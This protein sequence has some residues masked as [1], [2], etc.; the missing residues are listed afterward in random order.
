MNSKLYQ[1]APSHVTI[2]PTFKI[3]CI[4][5]YYDGITALHL[6]CFHVKEEMVKFLLTKKADPLIPGGDN[7][8]FPLHMVCTKQTGAALAILLN[9][10]KVSGKDA[11]MHKDKNGAIPLLLAAECGNH[12][13]CRELATQQ[14]QEQTEYLHPVSGD[15]AIHV[16]TRKKDITTVKKEGQAPLHIASQNGDVAMA[17]VFFHAKANPNIQDN[18][19]RTPLHI[20]AQA[21]STSI[22]DFLTDKFKASVFERTKDGSTLIHIASE[23]GHPET[24]MVFLRKG[25]PLHMPNKAGARCIHIAA[26]RGHV[27]VV[28]A[29]LMKGENVDTKTNDNH[30]ALHIAVKHCKPLVV[31]LLLGYGAQVHI[32]AGETSET[33]LHIAARVQNGEK[34]AEMLLKSGT[35]VNS[36]QLNGETALH[37][38]AR[39]GHLKTTRLLLD[40]GALPTKRTN[41]GLTPLHMAINNCRYEVVRELLDLMESRNDR[42]ASEKLVNQ[43]T[44]DGKTSIHYAAAITKEQCSYENEDIEMIQLLLAYKGNVNLQ[45]TKT[46]ETPL[47][48]CAQG[49]N[50]SVLKEIVNHMDP[51]QLQISMN[52]QA[53]N[54]MSSLMMACEKGHLETVTLLLQHHARVD[55]FDE[56]GRM[57][58]HLAAEN[59]HWAVIDVLLAHKAFVNAK[60][61]SGVTPLHLAAMKGY[62]SLV[63]LLVEKFHA[64][65]DALTIKKRTPLHC[66]AETGQLE[67]CK[68][69]LDMKADTNAT[70]VY[71]QTPLHLGAENDHSDVVKLFLY[72]SPEL[73]TMANTKGFT[74]AHIAAMKGSVGVMKELMKFN[75]NIVTTAKT[76]VADSTTLHLAAEGGHADVVK[77]LLE[78]G[79]APDIENS[80]GLTAIHLAARYGHVGVLDALRTA[81]NTA[82]TSKKTGFTALHVAA[83]YGQTEFVRE[84][85]TEVPAT[86]KSEAPLTDPNSDAEL[87]PLHLA[88]KSGYESVVRLLLNSDGVQADARTTVTGMTPLHF[89]AQGGHV[90]VVGLLLSKSTSQLHIKD[91]FGRTGLH[92]ATEKGHY[93]MVA[94]L[95]GQG[96]EIN[97]AD[98]NG[99]T[100]LHYTAK[101]GFLNV[102]KLLCDSGALPSS[103]TKDA[104]IPLCLAAASNHY[105]VLNYLVH[106]D[107]STESLLEDKNRLVLGARAAANEKSY[108]PAWSGFNCLVSTTKVPVAVIRYLPFINANPSDYSTIYTTLLK[109]VSIAKALGQGRILVT[110]DLAIYSKAQ[111][112]LW[113]RPDAIADMIT[114]RLG[115]MMAFIASIDKLFGD[116]GLY[117]LLTESNVYAT[118]TVTQMFLG[119]QY[120]RGMRGIRLVHEGMYQQFLRSA[121]QF[122]NEHRLP[123]F[124]EDII[125]FVNELEDSFRLKDRHACTA[126]CQEAES[127][128]SSNVIETIEAFRKAGREQSTTFCYWDTFLEMG[129]ILLR[130]TRA[131]REANLS[132]H[133]DA[134]MKAIPF[135][136][137]AG[138]VNCARTV[139]VAEMKELDTKDPNMFNHMKSGGFV[140]K[141]AEDKM[142]NCVPT[143]QALEPTINR[144]AKTQGGIIGF[145]SRKGALLRWLL[146]RH[147]TGEY[148][149]AFK[150]ICVNHGFSLFHDELGNA[151][152]QQDRKDATNIKEFIQSQCQN[153]FDLDNIPS[154]LVNITTGQVAT[155][156]VEKSLIGATEKCQKAT[157]ELF[158]ERIDKRSSGSFWDPLPRCPVVTFSSKKKALSYDK[159]RKLIID[160]EILFR[161]LLSV[162]KNCEVDM[163]SVLSFELAAVPPSLFHDDGS[164][165]KTTKAELT[166]KLEESC[167]N[168]ITELPEILPS[169]S[170]VYIN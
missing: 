91:S 6:A 126:I 83:N 37:F 70:D 90:P 21:G 80:D 170:S 144:E 115:G 140:V 20:A 31:E 10:L 60:S 143:D 11:R 118:S 135:F 157:D 139:Y 57:A 127:K 4:F 146:T 168:V 151:R 13:I 121:E 55:V 123:W 78:A 30:T 63:M 69:L 117:N 96:A 43:Q 86:C 71:G 33:P 158:A 84:M 100:A 19:H 160:T 148:S 12:G 85:L 154:T 79:A 163:R 113:T 111:Q 5:Y 64:V 161:R 32:K 128:I 97:A 124:S 94:L 62:S 155:P 74:C 102:V 164:M 14:T 18:E 3:I 103:E 87:T 152:M 22:V 88:A 120:S 53:K 67:V 23:N 81:M 142:F 106:K 169:C 7:E 16:S 147:V 133:L 141:R 109:L 77:A 39:Y 132:M 145:T 44:L 61:K 110:A 36:A 159:D 122:A 42:E 45:T 28:R 105:D 26:Q 50:V 35:D 73:S 40:D 38:S 82:I 137:L 136:F 166:K 49:G 58:L 66:A 8:Q 72:H 167:T 51:H 119:K 1:I 47:H 25:V 29:L 59:G 112:I 149:E 101:A 76:K 92:L 89:A 17:K 162:S 75:M 153:P 54:G 98:N 46:F 34:C 65:I 156:E 134:V 41:E 24:A 108:I 68:M 99:W 130:L 27:E 15:A 93:D 2:R 104:K 125:R 56:N 129:D 95:I 52:K 48:F 107:H 9:I 131:D 114:M 165:R 150:D 138:R 116:G